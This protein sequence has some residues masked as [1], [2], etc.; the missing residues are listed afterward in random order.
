MNL[1]CIIL[2]GP[3]Y[4]FFSVFL[5]NALFELEVQANT[6]CKTCNNKKV[7]KSVEG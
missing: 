5:S 6:I 4:L 1:T 7:G 3:D 2:E